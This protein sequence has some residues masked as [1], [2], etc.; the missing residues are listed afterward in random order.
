[1]QKL[2][3]FFPLLQFLPAPPFLSIYPTKCSFSSK[4]NKPNNNKKKTKKYHWNKT[5][6]KDHKRTGSSFCVDLAQGLPWCVTPAEKSNKIS[7]LLNPHQRS[8][9]LQ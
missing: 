4:R 3:L 6:Q 9:V 1:M 5:K 8:R 2:I 7:A